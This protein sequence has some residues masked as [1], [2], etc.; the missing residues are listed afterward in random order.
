[1]SLNDLPSLVTA[2]RAAAQAGDTAKA[3][4][5]YKAALRIEKRNH[6]LLMEAGVTA[7]QDGDMNAARDLLIAATKV[8]DQ[9]AD[10]QFNLGHV[11]LNQRLFDPALRAFQRARE[12]DPA[13]PDL[14]LPALQRL[15][16]AAIA[17]TGAREAVLAAASSGSTA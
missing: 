8:S 14:D 5:H 3:L 17:E 6:T 16:A 12:L 11:Y 7:A 10:V 13:Y 9:S 4:R 2:A 1:M 15:L